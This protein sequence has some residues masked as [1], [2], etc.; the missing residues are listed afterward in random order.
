MRNNKILPYYQN[1]NKNIQKKNLKF[2]YEYVLLIPVFV[3]M[4]TLL[5]LMSIENRI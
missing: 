5:Y 4:L 2:F 1:K 3:Y